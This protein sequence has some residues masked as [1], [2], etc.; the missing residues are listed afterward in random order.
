MG[1]IKIRVLHTISETDFGPYHNWQCDLAPTVRNTR[2][3]VM[4][5]AR[6]LAKELQ[7]SGIDSTIDVST[8]RNPYPSE[9]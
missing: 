8:A 4:R 5:E 9:W 3:H 7:A 6:Q 1:P 2:E